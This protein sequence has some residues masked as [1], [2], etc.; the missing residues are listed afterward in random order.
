MVVIF[1]VVFNPVLEKI[2]G[3]Y[4]NFLFLA[5]LV[6]VAM[7]VINMRLVIYQTS[8]NPYEFA[9]LQLL[10]LVLE[11]MFVLILI[12]YLEGG[13]KERVYSMVLACVRAILFFHYSAVEQVNP[14]SG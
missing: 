7:F 9:K 14:S 2:T 10:K 6:S 11:G 12:F 1:T 4:F 13:G 3:L 5:L 8:R